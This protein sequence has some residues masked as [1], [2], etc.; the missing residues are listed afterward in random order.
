[1]LKYIIRRLAMLIPVLLGVSLITFSLIHLIPGDPARSMLGEKA[2]Q[3]QLELLREEMGLN[4]PFIV[5]Y[6]R[7]LGHIAQGDLGTSIQK[8]KISLHS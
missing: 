2:S 6:G 4:D 7:F 5:Q 3:Q 8:K 1:M